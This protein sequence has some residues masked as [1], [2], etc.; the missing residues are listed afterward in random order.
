M[1]CCVSGG[2]KKNKKRK[3]QNQSGYQAKTSAEARSGLDGDGQARPPPPRPFLWDHDDKWGFSAF[4]VRSCD[5][6]RVL[7]VAAGP[8][9]YCHADAEL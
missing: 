9:A 5:P 8:F 4:S 6:T 2:A 7:E 3:Q 1:A